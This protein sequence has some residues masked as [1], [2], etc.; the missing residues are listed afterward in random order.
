[1]KK[2]FGMAF[3]VLYFTACS[4]TNNA[5]LET[6]SGPSGKSINVDELTLAT[7]NI[8]HLSFPTEMGCKPR[9]QAEINEMKAY[10]NS[11]DADIFALQE[12]ASVEAV[13]QVFAADKW[14]II[15]SGRAPSQAYTCR[16]S[17]NLSTQ[18][19]V[20]FAI[21][22]HVPIS[23]SKNYPELALG[24]EGL[25]Y[26]LSVTIATPQG[27]TEILNLH[28]KSGCF[29][30]NYTRAD[31]KACEVV[32][33]QAPILDA[34]IEAKELSQQ[35]YII[36][37]DF[38]HR[39]SAPYNQL[40]Q[41]L[42]TNSDASVSTL[43]NTTADVIGCHPYYPAP[44]DHIL[45]GGFQSPTLTLTSRTHKFENMQ[46]DEMLSDHC[47]VTLSISSQPL[48][49]SPSVKWL[50]TSKEYQFLTRE[51][52]QRATNT[53]EQ[54]APSQSSWVVVMDVDETILDNSPYQ[55]SLDR[56][57]TSYVPKTWEQW[58]KQGTAGLVPGAAAFIQR[59]VDKGGKLAL[60]TN[61]EKNTESYTWQN[62][63]AL[64]LPVK[65]ENTCLL[66][67]TDADK[68]AVDGK[69]LINDKDLRRQQVTSGQ[70]ACYAPESSPAQAWSQPQQ[71]LMQVGD[72]IEDF[73]GV[74]QEE[75]DISDL[76][77]QQPRTL[78]LLPN[79]MYGSW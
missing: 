9:G 7:W 3:V 50:T 69:I 40:T 22:H 51:V 62:L 1:M 15:V 29:V 43:Q 12:V 46:V 45:A 35:P 23:A 58:V 39:L 65:P 72:N 25:R 27:E 57:G 34:W 38:N 74:T 16:E 61:R 4:V 77:M 44:I 56:T 24:R 70:A 54:L 19:K 64:G 47:A 18:Q 79:P 42:F 5:S 36:L 13:Q 68:K 21:R 32:A 30:D 28:L 48:A 63:V 66:G 75:A 20:A 55:V 67:R 53:L 11:V 8:E 41:T 73:S 6:P 31:S 59:V 26:G 2:L 76:L 14:Q 17:G 71:I 52:Y 78:I 33:K 49:L 37:G 60:I 10:V